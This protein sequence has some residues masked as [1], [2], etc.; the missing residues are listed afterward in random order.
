MAHPT[1][2]QDRTLEQACTMVLFVALE[3]RGY[4]ETFSHCCNEIKRPPCG[5]ETRGDRRGRVCSA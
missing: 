3:L 2:L 4:P 1:T 5:H